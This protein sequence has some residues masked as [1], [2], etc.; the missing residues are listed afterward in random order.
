MA[1]IPNP[2]PDM[3]GGVLVE[4]GWVTGFTRRGL[5]ASRATTSSACRSPSAEAF[6]ALEDGVPAESVMR[7][8]PAAHRENAPVDRGFVV[9]A[10]FSDIG[11]PADY[12]QTSLRP[13]RP[14]GRPIWS[15]V[16]DATIDPSAR[17]DR[18]AVWDDVTIGATAALE[19]C[20]V[21]DGVQRAGGIAATGAC[22]LVPYAG[23]PLGR[24]SGVEGDLLIRATF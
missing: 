1:L 14:R 13:R 3:Y 6:L 17:V 10:P 4:D 21:C 18:T 11:T 20:I 12:L 23:Q 22:A 24:T 7:L 15:A 9:D 5:R 2:R 16:G 8:Y 19:D